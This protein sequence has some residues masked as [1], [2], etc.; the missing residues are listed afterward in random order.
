MHEDLTTFLMCKLVKVDK[1]SVTYIS[2][3]ETPGLHEA[4]QLKLR[5]KSKNVMVFFRA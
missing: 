4:S 1:L 3:F 2:C 5:F